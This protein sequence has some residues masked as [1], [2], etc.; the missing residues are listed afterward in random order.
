MPAEKDPWAWR[1]A[2]GLGGEQWDHSHLAP[3]PPTFV[4][5]KKEVCLKSICHHFYSNF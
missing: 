5:G 4:G 3:A 2:M 1:S